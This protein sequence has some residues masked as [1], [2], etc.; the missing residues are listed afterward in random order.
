MKEIL[1]KII[2]A[3]GEIFP[4]KHGAWLRLYVYA[5]NY[6]LLDTWNGEIYHHKGC[7]PSSADNMYRCV[8]V[9]S[10]EQGVVRGQMCNFWRMHVN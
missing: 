9:F 3:R 10:G 1:M 7:K 4:K 8:Y 6:L 2:R 5:D